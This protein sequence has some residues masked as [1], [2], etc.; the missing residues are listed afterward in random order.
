[1]STVHTTPDGTRVNPK[2]AVPILLFV[3]VFSL[4]IDNGFETMTMPMA[5]GLGIS[6]NTASLQAS[7]AGV[8]IGIGA[9]VYS[10][11]ADSSSIRK[12]MLTGVILVAVGSAIGFIF[13]DS[14]PMVLV[15]RYIWTIVMVFFVY[16]TQMG[17]IFLLPYAAQDYHGLSIDEASLLMIP[18]YVCAI[19][20]GIFSGKIGHVISSRA[21]VYTAWP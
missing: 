9:V 19:L 1:M 3:F 7:L 14:W 16:S 20:V 17:Y 6:D 13:S 21:T 15:G 4:V 11:L 10:A 5:A 8:I 12:L 2:A 18:G